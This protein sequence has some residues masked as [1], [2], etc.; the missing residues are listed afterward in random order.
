[1]F[2]SSML[3]DTHC[4]L[5][6]PAYDPD[7]DEVLDRA[8]AAGLAH[9]VVIGESPAASDR[10]LAP[11]RAARSPLRHRRDPPPRRQHLDPRV[12]DLAPRAA[13]ASPQS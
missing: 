11:G 8:W 9:V 3:V 2:S 10:A 6:D 4:H 13:A 5:A 7:R 1:M 12:G